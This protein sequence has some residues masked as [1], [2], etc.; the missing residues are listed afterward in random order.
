MPVLESLLGVAEVARLCRVPAS[1]I[2]QWLHDKKTPTPVRVNGLIR[3]HASTIDR[4][5]RQGCPTREKFDG[6]DA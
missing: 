1:T 2:W 3:F 6:G 4:W 5:I